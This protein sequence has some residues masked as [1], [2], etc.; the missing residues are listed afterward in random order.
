[1]LV[2]VTAIRTTVAPKAHRP[3]AFARASDVVGIF[4][5]GHRR[6]YVKPIDQKVTQEIVIRQDGDAAVPRVPMPPVVKISP[7]E[8]PTRRK[9][10]PRRVIG[11]EAKVHTDWQDLEG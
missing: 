3:V 1:V 10:N 4:H 2:D 9:R 8:S 5:Y 11:D 7:T 6:N